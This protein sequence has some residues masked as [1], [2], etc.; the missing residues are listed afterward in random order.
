GLTDAKTHRS[1]A[2]GSAE[3]ARALRRYEGER[4]AR[5]IRAQREARRNMLAY[6]ATFPLSLV[7]DLV[8]ARASGEQ[9][10]ARFD[11]LYGWSPDQS[12]V[13]H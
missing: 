13:Q 12:S 7:R 1:A 9:L 4:A 3:I 10:L 6:H 5:T 2:Q 11:W 8:L